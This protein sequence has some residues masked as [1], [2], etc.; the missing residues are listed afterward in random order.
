VAEPALVTGESPL[1]L[2]NKAGQLDHVGFSSGFN[3]EDR[4]KL[5]A[6]VTPFIAKNEPG[7]DPDAGFTGKAPGGPSRWT[8]P[9]RNTEWFP[10]KHKLV[11]EFQFDHF[12]GGRFRHGTTFLRWRPEKK[13]EQCGIE[14]VEVKRTSVRGRA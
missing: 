11:G 2:Y 9:D 8:T 10:L 12:S 1:G 3:H 5:K 13:P 4:K 14:Q 7:T 6:I